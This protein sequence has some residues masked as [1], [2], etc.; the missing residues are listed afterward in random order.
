ME[1]PKSGDKAGDFE[2]PTGVA[3]GTYYPKGYVV[4]VVDSAEMAEQAASELRSGGFTEGDV[5]TY[6][7]QTVVENHEQFLR[8]RNVLQRIGSAFASDEKEAVDEYIEEARRGRH[9]IT[10]HAPEEEHMERARQVLAPKGAYKMR[11]YGPS[12]MTDLSSHPS[13]GRSGA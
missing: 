9:F 6:S 7:G 5:R 11:H 8:Q 3:F 10:V 12:V 13:S 2:G 1:E 4:A